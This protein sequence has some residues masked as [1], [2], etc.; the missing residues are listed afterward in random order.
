MP[1]RSPTTTTS[2]TATRAADLERLLTIREVAELEATST[3]TI[4]RRIDAGELPAMKSG[5][6][7]RIRPQDLRAYRLQKLLGQ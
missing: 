4:R 6:Q 2:K 1:T 3:K 5:R 7:L